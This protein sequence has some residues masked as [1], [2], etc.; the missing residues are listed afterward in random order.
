MKIAVSELILRISSLSLIRSTRLWIS[1][2]L[3]DRRSRVLI[4]KNALN[5]NISKPHFA[6]DQSKTTTAQLHAQPLLPLGSK[7]FPDQTLCLF[8]P[9][10]LQ[11]NKCCQY[12]RPSRRSLGGTPCA[13][14]PHPVQ[15]NFKDPREPHTT[16]RQA[17]RLSDVNKHSGI[18]AS[19]RLKHCCGQCCLTC[20]VGWC[21]RECVGCFDVQWCFS[22]P[23]KGLWRK[24]R[25]F[26][27][28]A[29]SLSIKVKCQNRQLGDMVSVEFSL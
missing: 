24:G 6:L 23:L 29:K 10:C 11:K 27:H 5:P 3:Y 2:H 17:R 26:N 4:Q 20:H 7:I 22:W 13:I 16:D 15:D 1:S 9:M 14:A 25:V 28:N 19:K 18:L 12:G 8:L 21:G